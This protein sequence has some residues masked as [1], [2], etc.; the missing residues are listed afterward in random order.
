MVVRSEIDACITPTDP[1][2]ED[3]EI[4][5]NCDVAPSQTLSTDPILTPCG[6]RIIPSSNPPTPQSRLLEL[7]TIKSSTFPTWNARERYPQ[8]YFSQVPN[9]Y[10]A[11]HVEG[12]ISQINK[13]DL[14]KSPEML[15]YAPIIEPKL[16]ML[17]T[18]LEMIQIA[19]ITG[20]R[21]SRGTKCFSLVYTQGRLSLF[22]RTGDRCLPDEAFDMFDA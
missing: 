14:H 5:F 13:R 2:S 4:G 12:T 15:F 21:R 11:S 7:S 22:E 1:L 9:H 8:L 10:L 20:V 19:V 17:R 6:L 18:L 3:D 16:R